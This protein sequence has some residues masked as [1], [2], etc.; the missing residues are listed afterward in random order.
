MNDPHSKRILFVFAMVLTSL[1]SQCD[2]PVAPF[3]YEDEFESKRQSRIVIEA[4][5]MKGQPLSDYTVSIDG[6]VNTE[7]VVVGQQFIL[8]DVASGHYAIQLRKLG[9]VS[10]H[11]P[12]TISY[13]DGVFSEV[14]LYLPVRLATI[15]ATKLIDAAAGGTF[16]GGASQRPG[17]D[18]VPTELTIQTGSLPGG[19]SPELSITRIPGT[20][21]AGSVITYE[22]LTII[23]V[24]GFNQ[25]GL[26]LARD[27]MWKIPLQV[28]AQIRNLRPKFWIIPTV[29]S[30]ETGE[31]TPNGDPIQ[32][33]TD[34][35]FDYATFVISE[36]GSYALATDLGL[37]LQ[38]SESVPLQVSRSACGI[39]SEALYEIDSGTAFSDI[40]YLNPFLPTQS[41]KISAMRSF[42]GVDRSRITVEAS[43]SV[44]TWQLLHPT[45]RSV[46]Q[47]SVINSGPIR[48]NVYQQRCLDS[49]GS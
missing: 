34:Q 42:S 40:L 15:E 29:W 36:L 12:I 14:Q 28:N 26:I 43:H 49:G 30:A 24:L 10:A 13:P 44:Q 47:Q 21:T 20:N 6:P 17:L 46:V 32:G 38:V 2:Q 9:Y 18:A 1:T 39:K 45:T 27:A 37:R 33:I 22:N 25:V 23:D 7:Q 11:V 3:G 41:Q 4:F 8:N 31:F 35:N 5:D 19:A 16:Y 48:F